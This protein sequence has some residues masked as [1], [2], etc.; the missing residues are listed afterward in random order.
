MAELWEQ[1]AKFLF[2]E[3]NWLKGNSEEK[4]LSSYNKVL[5]YLS[6]GFDF[7]QMQML[8][9]AAISLLFSTNVYHWKISLLQRTAKFLWTSAIN[10]LSTSPAHWAV[11]KSRG[12][13]CDCYEVHL[14]TCHRITSS[15]TPPN[16]L[17]MFFSGDHLIVHPQFHLLKARWLIQYEGEAITEPNGWLATWSWIFIQPVH[18]TTHSRLQGIYTYK[19][20]PTNLQWCAWTFEK[21]FYP[22]SKD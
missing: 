18:S 19:D 15:Y 13:A 4:G 9:S 7:K 22:I 6:I 14:P 21:S 12:G 11:L 8:V 3:E 2:F 5:H 17:P 20:Q 16:S 10:I 1:S